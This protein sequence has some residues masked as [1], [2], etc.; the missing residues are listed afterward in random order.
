MIY[1]RYPEWDGVE[2]RGFTYDSYLWEFTS[3][4]DYLNTTFN[5]NAIIT[6]FEFEEPLD[7]VINDNIKQVSLIQTSTISNNSPGDLSEVIANE[8]TKTESHTISFSRA[9]THTNSYSTKTT[10]SA[11][12]NVNFWVIHGKITTTEEFDYYREDSYANTEGSEQ[13]LTKDVTYSISKTVNVLPYETVK[14]SSYLKWIDNLQMQYKANIVITL[15]KKCGEFLPQNYTKYILDMI[16]FDEE[17]ANQTTYTLVYKT[18][19]VYTASMGLDSV[20][21]VT[22]V[23]HECQCNNTK[24]TP[25][26]VYNSTNIRAKYYKLKKRKL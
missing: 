9:V 4:I 5:L 20:F 24:Q 1:C 15:S 18:S 10:V 12:V 14:V 21:T 13:T 19:G 2:F 17:F 3:F 22:S 6:D 8:V 16:G 26:V 7:D 25:K 11:E 23:D